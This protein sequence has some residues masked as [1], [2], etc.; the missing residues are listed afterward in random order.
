MR[1]G[2]MKVIIEIMRDVKTRIQEAAETAVFTGQERA[3][4]VKR[5]W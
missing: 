5:E 3:F 2:D 1:V 4:I